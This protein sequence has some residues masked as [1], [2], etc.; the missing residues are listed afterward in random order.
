M[1]KV[2][3]INLNNEKYNETLTLPF[4]PPYYYQNYKYYYKHYKQHLSSFFNINY[5]DICYVYVTLHNTFSIWNCIIKNNKNVVIYYNGKM[6]NKNY[7][8]AKH[9]N[10]LIPSGTELLICKYKLQN[11]GT[12]DINYTLCKSEIVI[13]A[14]F[15]FKNLYS[16]LN[17]KPPSILHNAII[18]KSLL[19]NSKNDEASPLLRK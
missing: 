19:R 4:P 8:A 9:N 5:S 7:Y 17:L 10:Y 13:N 6:N 14:S 1:T 3:L 12:H 18:Y 16:S 11:M 15:I 2:L